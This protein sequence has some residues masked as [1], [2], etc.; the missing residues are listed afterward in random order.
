MMATVSSIQ[1]RMPFRWARIAQ[2][3]FV[4]GVAVFLCGCSGTTGP[5]NCVEW[6][7]VEKALQNDYQEA[8]WRDV[9]SNEGIRMPLIAVLRTDN[10]LHAILL[11]RDGAGY[12]EY[13]D[14]GFLTGLPGS[15]G[16]IAKDELQKKL[17]WFLV[18][19]QSPVPSS[20]HSQPVANVR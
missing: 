17:A 7:K 12:Y 19:K 9:L 8:S 4:F 2:L 20:A 11:V 18:E 1:A 3:L 6:C 15:K 14:N 5:T 16:V 10:G 13:K